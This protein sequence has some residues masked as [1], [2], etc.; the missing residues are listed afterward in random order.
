MTTEY[1]STANGTCS[2]DAPVTRNFT[3]GAKATSMMRS[4]TD[5]CTS[6]YAGSPSARYDQTKTI[7]V[8]GAAARMI[9]P[10]MYW[11]ASSGPMSGRK[12]C[13]KKSQ[14]KTPSRTA[15]PAS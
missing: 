6:V 4:L 2:P 12:R 1:S 10:A 15:S 8:Q 13:R 5:T 11:L 14:P 7:A 3:I 9:T